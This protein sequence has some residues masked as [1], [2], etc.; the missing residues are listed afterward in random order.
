MTIKILH[1]TEAEGKDSTG[2]EVTMLAAVHYYGEDKA[3][4]GVISIFE[5]NAKRWHNNR[6]A[7]QR[8]LSPA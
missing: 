2:L 4:A 3:T 6:L 8:K 5:E 7:L 1:T